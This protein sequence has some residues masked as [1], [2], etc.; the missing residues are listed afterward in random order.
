MPRKGR[1]PNAIPHKS[2][3]LWLP[4]KMLLEVQVYLPRD[5]ITGKVKHG[6]WSAYFTQLAREDLE[7][8]AKTQGVG[9]NV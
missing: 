5:L 7:R 3:E 9:Q 4:A 6:A 1:P 8:K 2:I